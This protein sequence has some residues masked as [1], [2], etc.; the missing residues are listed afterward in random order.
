MT[1]SLQ[2]AEGYPE[3][4]LQETAANALARVESAWKDIERNI[5]DSLLGTYNRS[6]ADPEEGFPEL[7]RED[8]LGRIVLKAIRVIE[9]DSVS[10]VFE[11]SGIFGGH[12][13]EIFWA[14]ERMHPASLFG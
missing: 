10:L 7:S 14:P 11:D 13:A 1:I 12:A 4:R 8:F 5:A 6:W 2:L 9:E 3:A